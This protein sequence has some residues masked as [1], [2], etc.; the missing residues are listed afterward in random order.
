M[1]LPLSAE[2]Y[3]Y[4]GRGPQETYWDRKAGARMGIWETS[5][6]DSYVAYVRPQENGHHV[7]CQWLEFAPL[8]LVGECF[9]FNALRNCVEDFDSE[10]A[11]QHDY[12]WDNLH[13]DEDHSPENA[14]DARRRQHHIDDIVP[15]DYVE[16]CLDGVQTGIGGYDSWGQRT[17]PERTHFS[18]ED[19]SFSFTMVPDGATGF[20]KAYRYAY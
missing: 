8:T 15:R 19:F 12:Q 11:V 14:K 17:D 5:A 16:L 13:A 9:E 4:F 6:T 1:R 10:E 18:N 20:R 7:D 3:T 2:E